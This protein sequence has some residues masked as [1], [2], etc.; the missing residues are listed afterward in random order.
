MFNQ[1]V[2]VLFILS[3]LHVVHRSPARFSFVARLGRPDVLHRWWYFDG[4]FPPR[5]LFLFVRVLSKRFVVVYIWFS[6][7]HSNCCGCA[8]NVRSGALPGS[9]CCRQRAHWPFWSRLS[10]R[11][12]SSRFLPPVAGPA[13]R[14]VVLGREVVSRKSSSQNRAF[15]CPFCKASS[16]GRRAAS[17]S[18]SFQLGSSFLKSMKKSLG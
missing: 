17:Q 1:V 16:F 11:C 13:V 10:G 15:S 4:E 18:L 8:R 12:L 2:S 6:A 3:W 7:F 5:F 14:E 9:V